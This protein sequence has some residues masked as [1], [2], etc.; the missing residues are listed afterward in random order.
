[1][2]GFIAWVLAIIF[3]EQCNDAYYFETAFSIIP[4]LNQLRHPS[5]L[6]IIYF[7]T[8]PITVIIGA[9]ALR[10]KHHDG[11]EARLL[12]MQFTSNQDQLKDELF[13]GIGLALLDKGTQ[14]APSVP[15]NSLKNIPN[16]TP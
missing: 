12:E 8:F 2:G 13:K 4:T 5:V 9:I 10:L 11:Q 7:F 1:M 16:T 15:S 3:C 6:A 14:Y